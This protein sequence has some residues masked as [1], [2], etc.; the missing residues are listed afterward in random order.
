MLHDAL[1]AM[2]GRS[3]DTLPSAQLLHM[4]GTAPDTHLLLDGHELG[5]HANFV[6]PAALDCLHKLGGL[7]LKTLQCWCVRP[8][9]GLHASDY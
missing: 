5:Y 4:T 3:T 8:C 2:T 7:I 1:Q 9:M 6:L